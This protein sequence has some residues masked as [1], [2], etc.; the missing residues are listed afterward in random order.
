[1]RLGDRID[2]ALHRLRAV[3]IE[4][5]GARMSLAEA[6]RLTELETHICQVLLSALEDLSFLKRQEDGAYRRQ[7]NK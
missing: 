5:P 7:S 4:I 1:V 3:F 2:R 6:A